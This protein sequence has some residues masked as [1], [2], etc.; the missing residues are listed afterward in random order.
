MNV[1][2]L[3]EDSEV[4]CAEHPPFFS[5]LTRILNTCREAKLLMG[6]MR[7]PRMECMAL[8]SMSQPMVLLFAWSKRSVGF[9]N[10]LTDL[11]LPSFLLLLSSTIFFRSS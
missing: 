6:P 1:D 7:L 5:R 4:L 2:G 8:A 11:F 3:P 10:P 9:K